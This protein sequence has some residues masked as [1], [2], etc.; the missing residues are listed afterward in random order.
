MVPASL[1]CLRRTDEN[2]G[3]G[4]W[5]GGENGRSDSS[6]KRLSAPEAGDRAHSPCFLMKTRLK[7]PSCSAGYGRTC[8]CFRHCQTLRRTMPSLYVFTAIP[9]PCP[10]FSS[11]FLLIPTPHLPRLST[12]PLPIALSSPS[13]SPSA[14]ELPFL[15][16][17]SAQKQSGYK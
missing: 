2:R 4:G 12:T 7:A 8:P 5:D 1:F 6:S 11:C 14:D 16:K 17:S 3:A 10:L 9:S 13:P 15:A